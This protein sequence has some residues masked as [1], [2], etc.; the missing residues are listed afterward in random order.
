LAAAIAAFVWAFRRNRPLFFL[1][2]VAGLSLLP[3]SNLLFPI[4]TIMAE[5]FLYLPAIAA[6]ACAVA[7]LFWLANRISRPR[8]AIVVAGCLI[9]LCASRTWRRNAD[10]QD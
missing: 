5:R 6:A 4:G 8:L 9:L 7:G 1:L 10:W 2:A 3:V